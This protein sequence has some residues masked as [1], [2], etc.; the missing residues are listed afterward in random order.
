MAWSYG[1]RR[2]LMS[3]FMFLGVEYGML[4]AVPTE[5]PQLGLGRLINEHFYYQSYIMLL[6]FEMKTWFGKHDTST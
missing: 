3:L 2:I 1:E 5:G 4:P 6:S